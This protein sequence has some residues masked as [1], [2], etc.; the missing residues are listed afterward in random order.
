MLKTAFSRRA[1][2]DD[3]EDVEITGRTGL[4]P[5]KVSKLSRTSMARNSNNLSAYLLSRALESTFP[6]LEALL[7]RMTST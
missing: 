5:A 3:D 4:G 2:D 1:I 6:H 7:T